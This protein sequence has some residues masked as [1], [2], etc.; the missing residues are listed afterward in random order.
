MAQLGSE[1][2]DQGQAPCT[3]GN[4]HS[5]H[6]CCNTLS[7]PRCAACMRPAPPLKP[8]SR[9]PQHQQQCQRRR[10]KP[11][12]RPHAHAHPLAP[13]PARRRAQS[14]TSPSPLRPSWHLSS[15]PAPWHP[16][17][18][19]RVGGQPLQHHI[20]D[21]QEQVQAPPAEWRRRLALPSSGP[22]AGAE[23]LAS[24]QRW[25]RA[26]PSQQEAGPSTPSRDQSGTPQP[27]CLE[28]RR[29]LCT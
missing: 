29:A 19:A 15:P 12:A 22:A 2:G 4:Q 10:R 14:R 16:A 24:G 28:K 27:A 26:R 7:A 18:Q 13:R 1:V 9:P 3:S 5:A 20:T 8:P 21:V 11:A 17:Q 25:C 6:A 23:R